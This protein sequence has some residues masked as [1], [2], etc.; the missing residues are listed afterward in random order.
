MLKNH[1]PL[2]NNNLQDYPEGTNLFFEDIEL[3]D[4]IGPLEKV[5]ADEDVIDFCN[6]WGPPTPNRFTDADEAAKSKLSGPI[7][8]GIMTMAL[9]AQLFTDWSSEDS[10]KDLNLVF[11]Q[12]VPH[13]KTLIIGATVTDTRQEGEE[14]LIDCDVVMTGQESERYVIGTATVSL[15]SRNSG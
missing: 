6:L 15:P 3:G 10:L 14:H 1:S 5:A 11:R 9:M 13:N 12:S 2:G 7:V 8:P 4:E